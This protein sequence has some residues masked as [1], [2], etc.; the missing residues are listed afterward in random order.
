MGDGL[1]ETKDKHD[2]DYF[3][4]GN[5]TGYVSLLNNSSCSI[6]RSGMTKTTLSTNDIKFQIE[7]PMYAC[8]PMRKTSQWSAVDPQNLKVSDRE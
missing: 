2:P 4:S 3:D 6:K 5:Y 8:P 7:K 1:L